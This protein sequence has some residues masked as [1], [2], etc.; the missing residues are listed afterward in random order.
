MKLEWSYLTSSSYNSLRFISHFVV[1]IAEVKCNVNSIQYPACDDDELCVCFRLNDMLIIVSES[2]VRWQICRSAPLRILFIHHSPTL[3]IRVTPFPVHITTA[4][5]A[6]ELQCHPWSFTP[7]TSL[8]RG[9]MGHRRAEHLMSW[10]VRAG[11]ACAVDVHGGW[12]RVIDP[13]DVKQ[14][15]PLLSLLSSSIG[16]ARHVIES[17]KWIERAPK[18]SAANFQ[19]VPTRAA[20]TA[21]MSRW[22]GRWICRRRRCCRHRHRMSFARPQ[23]FFYAPLA[24]NAMYRYSVIW[25]RYI[26]RHGNV[27]DM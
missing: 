27:Y 22:V 3:C 8:A 24:E 15:D 21:L 12:S 17:G 14:N 19:R 7:R 5:A 9:G 16:F 6:A 20:L 11:H 23:F 4:A 26:T 2:H 10:T 18:D 25:L 1:F 13:H